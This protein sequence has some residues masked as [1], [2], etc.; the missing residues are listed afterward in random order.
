MANLLTTDTTHCM[1][2]PLMAHTTA[3]LEKMKIPGKKLGISDTAALL[4][5]DWITMHPAKK[6]IL[7]RNPVEINNSIRSLGLTE[8]NAQQHA[9][10][11]DRL[12]GV[13][14]YDWRSVFKP[15]V[16]YEICRLL[17]VPF[18]PYRFEELK[19]MNIQ[20]HFAQ[21]SVGREAAQELV[22][23]LAKEIE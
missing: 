4:F 2:D 5:P 9:A 15:A 13:P 10:R 6:V 21:V 19:A 11:V 17:E 18:C 22:R 23:R 7:W 1:H 16:A 14:M 20:P 8:I 3:Q 12:K